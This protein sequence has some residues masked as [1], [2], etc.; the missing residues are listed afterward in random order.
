MKIKT[1]QIYYNSNCI[2]GFK[3]FAKDSTLLW[4]IG[5][6]TASSCDVETV[7]LEDN[8]VIIGVVAKLHP[9]KQSAYTDFQFKLGK[10]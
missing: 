3:F 8:E 5:Y 10:E 4:K 1:V 7:E 9:D 2:F 6:T